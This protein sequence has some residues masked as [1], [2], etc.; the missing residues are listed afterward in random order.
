MRERGRRPH[1]TDCCLQLERKP[2]QLRGDI[3]P[4]TGKAAS[5]RALRITSFPGFYKDVYERV[6]DCNKGQ[7][8]LL[9]LIQRDTQLLERCLERR[10]GREGAFEIVCLR[11][12]AA[13]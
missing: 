8:H 10:L 7:P 13:I 11:K 2:T 9:E 5:V 3:C 4:P 6:P 1:S 12:T